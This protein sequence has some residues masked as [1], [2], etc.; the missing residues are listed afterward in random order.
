MHVRK[1]FVPYTELMKLNKV[2]VLAL[3]LAAL[4]KESFMAFSISFIMLCISFFFQSDL[5]AGYRFHL[6]LLSCSSLAIFL[7]CVFD[8]KKT[9]PFST[10]IAFT[11]SCFL[12]FYFSVFHFCSTATRPDICFFS[13]LILMPI[14]FFSNPIMLYPIL[15]IFTAFYI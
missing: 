12:L 13:L 11:Y 14:I 1:N 10:V 7:L 8:S 3:N 15:G 4:Q 6:V 2:Q 5:W 9:L